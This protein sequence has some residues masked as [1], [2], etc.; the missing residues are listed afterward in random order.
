MSTSAADIV[1]DT[2]ITYQ[3]RSEMRSLAIKT[4]HDKLDWESVTDHEAEC[5]RGVFSRLFN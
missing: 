2:L 1:K 3:S 4:I 5:L